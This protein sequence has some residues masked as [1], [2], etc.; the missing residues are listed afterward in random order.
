MTPTP[1]GFE[2]D[3]VVCDGKDNVKPPSLLD[4]SVSLDDG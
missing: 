4:G 2:G 3:Y 1:P